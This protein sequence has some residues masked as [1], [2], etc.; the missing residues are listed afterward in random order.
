VV[1]ACVLAAW[2]CAFQRGIAASVDTISG[3]WDCVGTREKGT[4]T[5]KFE[6]TF[7]VAEGG[8]V[9]GLF[10]DSSQVLSR[11]E[12]GW[13]DGRRLRVIYRTRINGEETKVTLTGELV[14]DAI[15]GEYVG[16]DSKGPWSGRWSAQRRPG[17]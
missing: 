10:K 12:D 1:V 2:A 13:F 8:V 11:L 3:V 14:E 7:R 9:T 17:K 16:E 15:V 6:L 4:S 5:V